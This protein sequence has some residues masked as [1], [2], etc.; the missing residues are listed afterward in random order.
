MDFRGGQFINFQKELAI[1]WCNR[2]NALF[3]L[4]KWD[5]ALISA[6][7]S[8]RLNHRNIKA[9]YR[10]G[11]SFIKLHDTHS[12]LM[13]FSSGLS[14]LSGS[15]EI[16]DIAEFL[17]GIFM[18]FEE[19]EFDPMFLRIFERILKESYS[20]QIWKVLIERL[21]NKKMFKSC[22]FLMERQEKL[23]KDICDLHVSLKAIFETYANS[24]W[25]RNTKPIT[26]LVWWLITMGANVEC[27][28]YPL[29]VIINL[30]IKS[31]DSS[32]FKQVLKNKPSLREKIN[33]KDKDGKT[34]LHIVASSYTSH[35]G[36]TVKRQTQ[37]IK[38]LLDYGSDPSIPDEQKNYVS[39]I[40]KRS[41]NFK[42]E[43]IIKKEMENLAC[44][45]FKTKELEATLSEKHELPT[46][47][48]KSLSFVSA[49]EQFISFCKQ[50]SVPTL[51]FLKH[52]KVRGFLHI[53]STIKDIP[54]GLDCD[55]PEY[56]VQEL[57]TQ[58][59]MQQRWQEVL[60]LLTGTVSGTSA[61]DNR[62][63]LKMCPLPDI[64]IG[65]VV[66]HLSPK[67]EA[68]LPLVKL[69]LDQGVPPDGV[70]ALCEPPICTC[71]KK[72]DFTLAYL[73]LKA[74]VNPQSITLKQGDTPLHAAAYI[75]LCLK[76][77]CGIMI[78]KHLLELYSSK[79]SE[80]PY[81][82]P[83]IQDC[84]GDTVMH[85]V[86]QSPY[87][88]Q[89]R[90]VMELLSKFDI[91][92]TLKNKL[93]KDAKHRIKNTDAHYIAWNEANKKKKHDPPSTSSKPKKTISNG[94]KTHTNLQT[95]TS[96]PSVEDSDYSNVEADI[97]INKHVLLN[98]PELNM[99]N[100]TKPTTAKDILVQVIQD[101]IKAMD[102]TRAPTESRI[103]MPSV[104]SATK[105]NHLISVCS[106]DT[107][108]QSEDFSEV[109]QTVDDVTEFDDN[110]H[111]AVGCNECETDLLE[112][113]LDISKTD[114]GNM[115]WEIECAPEA[116]KK[117]GSKAVPQY[118][119][120]KIIFS[121][122][123]L[124]NGEWTRSLHK[125]LKYLKCDIKLF[126]VKLDKGARML[127]ELA[128]DFSPRCSEKPETLIEDESSSHA[129]NKTGRVYT[130]MIRIWDIVLDHCKLSSAIDVICHAYNRGLTCILRK[131]LKGI[132]KP[133]FFSNVEK[134]VPLCFV[135]DIELESNM[136]HVLPN[137][138]PPASASETEYSIM[139]FHS[140][141]TDMAL[142]ILNNISTRVEY[143]F[144]VGEL[145]YAVIDLNPKPME[146]IILIGRSGTGKTTCCLYRL[147]KKFHSYWEK[148]ELI[149]GPW[150]VKQTWQRR[151]FEEN[152]EKS[153]TEDEDTTDE[154]DS[155]EEEQISL[156]LD[157]L[158][159]EEQLSESEDREEDPCKLEH[160]HPVFI[161]KNHV[162]CQEVQRNF[163]ELS[164]STQATNHYKPA[165][166]NVYR[167]QDLKDDCFP[168]FVTSQQFL[169]LLDASMPDP[170]FPRNEDGSIKRSIIG[171]SSSDEI[172]IPDLMRDYDGDDGELD[173]DKEETVCE[174]KESDPRVFVTFELFASE[175][176]P[177]MVKGKSCYNAALVWKE[178]KSFLKGSFEALNCHQG[179]LT[180]DEYYKLGKKRAPNFQED[181]KEIYRLFSIYEQIKSKKGYFDEEDVLYHLSC[182][183]SKL[184][185]LP[186]SIH[187]LY[188]DEIQDF[189]QAE[190]SLLMRCINDPNSMFLTGD[191]AQSIMKGVS[192]RFSD[193]RSLFYYANKNAKN[194]GKKC[195]VR[196][197]K[198]I[199]QL[200]QN[201]RSHSGIL[202][203]ASGV[204]DLLQYFF[205]ESFDRLPRDCGLFDGPKPTVLES[206][207][208]SDLAI[209]LRGNKRKAQPIEFGAH[210]VI[211]VKNESAKERIPEE[212]S[213]ALVLTI[214]EAK[215]LEFDDVLLYN[216]FTDSEAF[217]E[218]RII[219]TFSPE[220][221]SNVE[222]QPLIEISMDKVCMPVNRQLT[223]NPE[224]H[225]MLNVELKQLYTAVTRARVNLWI[226]DESQE[227]RAPAFGYFIKG[228]FV[229]VVRTDE[230]KD[231]D[232]NM[233]V[234]TS[235]KEEWISRGDYYASHKCWKVAAKCYQKGEATE[236][237]KLAFAHN[238]VLHLP[239]K[240]ASSRE[241][242]MEYLRLAKT[243]M[244]CREPKLAVKC[245][246]FAKEFHL[247]G[248]LC[249]KLEKNKDAAYF[250]KMIQNNAVAAQC[251]EEAGELEM[252]LNLYSQEK[253]YEEAALVIERHKKRNPNVHLPFTAKR[254]YLEAAAN[255]LSNNKLKKMNEILANLDVEDQLIFLKKHKRWSEAAS[256]LK[257]H[258]RC[259]EA[260][261]LMRDHG[262]LL[263]AADL[264]MN[265]EFRALCL[266]AAAKCHIKDCDGSNNIGTRIAEAVQIFKDIQN[267]IGVAEATLVEGIMTNDFGKLHFSFENF[268]TQSHCAGA[269]EALFEC[270]KCDEFNQK[271]LSMAASGLQRLITLLKALKATKTNADRE[272][273]K[274]CFEFFGVVHKEGDTCKVLQHEGA[275]ILKVFTEES[276]HVKDR[277]LELAYVKSLLERHFL[278]RLCD[279]STKVLENVY[280]ESDIC[281]K[282][283]VGLDCTDENCQDF[284]RPVL[285]HEF[286][287]MLFSKINLTT[288]SGLLFDARNLSKEYSNELQEI[289]GADVFRFPRSLLN[290]F[291][292]KHFHLR[293]LSENK[294]VCKMFE[295]IWR[296]FPKPCI[297]ML[298]EYGKS[299]FYQKVDKEKRES[300]DLWLEAMC[301]FSLS[302]CYPDE[303]KRLLDE[304]EVKFNRDY[305]RQSKYRHETK[306]DGRRLK[307]LGMLKPDVSSGSLKDSHIHF[308]RLFQSSL[309]NLYV[310]KNPETCKT[311]FFRFLNYIVKK[312]ICPLI[313][314]IGNSVMLL[315]FQF[316]FCCVV[317]MR[318][319]PSTRV[320]LPKSYI[321]VL[322]HWESM[323]GKKGKSVVKDTYSIL[324]EYK[325]R[326]E[327]QAMKIF[328]YH[329][330]YLA[331]VLCGE[332]E[333]NF[334]VLLD[335]FRDIDCIR[336]GEAERTLVLCLVMMVNVKGVMKPETDIILKKN[337]PL[338]QQELKNQ[339]ENFPLNV[340]ERL[341]NSVNN[342]PHNAAEIVD[343]LQNLLSQRDEEHLVECSWRWDASYFKGSVRGIF[344]NDKFK[345]K[346]FAD[347]QHITHSFQSPYFEEQEYFPEERVDI[348]ATLA[349][350]VQQK[351]SAKQQF[352]ELM[353]FVC[354][355]IKWKRAS[356]HAK[357]RR[358]EESTPDHFKVAG[359]DSTQCDICGVKFSLCPI[360]FSASTEEY[361]EEA[362]STIT[363]KVEKNDYFESQ[364]V[365]NMS[366]TYESHIKLESHRHQME[367]YN[368]YLQFYKL[369]VNTVL[370]EAKSLVQSL[371]QMTD[372]QLLSTELNLE[373]TKIKNKMKDVVDQ[374]EDIYERKK[375]SEAEMLIERPLQALATTLSEAQSVLNKVEQHMANQ[376]GLQK[377]DLFDHEIDYDFEELW[378]K[379]TKRSKK[380]AK[381]H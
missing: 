194:D 236:K 245:L 333:H 260:A 61:G 262:K 98:P 301:I 330:A 241:K 26:D 252:A 59:I 27:T 189:T 196:K 135:E 374:M 302:S 10:S 112:E 97:N 250:F 105:D 210:Q 143:P 254:Y 58:L 150:L 62:G 200:Y 220:S 266:L 280:P 346:E 151:H 264:T 51:N 160:Y 308:F 138:F 136:V 42:A 53:L 286:K 214:Y 128:I 39:D 224:L 227:K 87:Q 278:K 48:E 215:G 117:L 20:K 361:E 248:E 315:E 139:K 317:L 5:E 66:H 364:V 180:E 296:N 106:S 133:Q 55:I 270:M 355:C 219:S 226:F 115:T 283:I 153:D 92:L 56:V 342:L 381:R 76:V 152:V 247:C 114:F 181:R 1:L 104:T 217:K 285:Q 111:S 64:N 332:E 240:K 213:L 144:R 212:L 203:L 156:E 255:L 353:L 310:L 362:M 141:S 199:Y 176:W 70:G 274:S 22:L 347:V 80:Y 188:G 186:W 281:P 289:L 6:T 209:L 170:F 305:M 257:N 261:L 9:Y 299:L 222:S 258:G 359:I 134:R 75:A 320:L 221:H 367:A 323:F 357:K 207:S 7:R 237:E 158:N 269:V 85:M 100:T 45:S 230:N 65:H 369:Q 326:N 239:E 243:Y 57:I 3:K 192:F 375:W 32:L 306:E 202:H 149:G 82:N 23:P 352:H 46:Q 205:P 107:Q 89:Y 93:G 34:L 371:K 242:Q 44:H 49:L 41:K 36:Y 172:D 195:V 2:A 84:N 223:M 190:L 379:K 131:K 331:K 238:A 91:K 86:F 67:S 235:T 74:G 201:Y 339:K 325:P 350:Q 204:V 311:Y 68:R 72:N 343:F 140:F 344:Y 275:R 47:E 121:I 273:V 116:L 157:L 165:E 259:E 19:L 95:K 81:L 263:E 25:C 164:K 69:L 175:L 12:A 18:A 336:S 287:R 282:F 38:M 90:A 123:K 159:A 35:S 256:L 8:I 309:D 83:N 272:N 377:K 178:I 360:S 233:F 319:S 168:M 30:C 31:D 284:H 297:N 376:E 378:S 28:D 187:E 17:N 304:E 312:S 294:G 127:W 11:I 113:D 79:P 335:A 246:A 228:D 179:K 101:L 33:Q 218:W 292:P 271:L 193:L 229:K 185:E 96:L 161:T 366:V 208:V 118:M 349:S 351:H 78:M 291:F 162:L 324:M 307:N 198:R 88:K 183:L 368:S 13:M 380:K 173:N 253:M 124:G 290:L 63:L 231:L 232:D 174:L 197:P 265:K 146:A 130:E 99:V 94:N 16:E 298:T 145:E 234:R 370:S 251:F 15:S 328:K 14:M 327:D 54:P 321:S 279:I 372:D 348:V 154:T 182:Q 119:K 73:L 338:I 206:C 276:F 169:L 277:N 354:F 356:L 249:R 314:N 21:V 184:E 50:E 318:L 37:D 316:T 60:L 71:L 147:W 163:C 267:K 341:I 288:I 109:G 126:E 322:H 293:I 24:T 177:Q 43:S 167:L 334:N 373:Q 171:W 52:K 244:E 300:T 216:F 40:L 313:P 122:Q 120:N 363:N 295:D 125:Q 166:S 345:F 4:E 211:L 303:L 340:P 191:T 142:N 103:H 358:M 337:I 77:D 155:T 365:L 102:F 148:A 129:S 225:K 108:S 110:E 137:Y 132:T 29:H 268:V 329:L